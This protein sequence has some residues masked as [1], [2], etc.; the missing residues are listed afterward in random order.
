MSAL[1]PGPR[2]DRWLLEAAI[3]GCLTLVGLLRI[4]LRGDDD[5][6]ARAV[7]T[8]LVAALR[9]AGGIG[10]RKSGERAA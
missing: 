2:R 9:I 1:L 7:R 3:K 5:T 6:D 4:G 8:H 10:E